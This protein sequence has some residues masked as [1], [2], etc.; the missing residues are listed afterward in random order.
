MQNNKIHLGVVA[1]IA[2][3]SLWFFSCKA[4]PGIE[5]VNT[6]VIKLEEFKAKKKFAEDSISH[7]PGIAEESL[8]PVL[9][10]KINAAADDFIKV[11]RNGNAT[12]KE[13]QKAIG[14]GLGRFSDMYADTENSER[15]CAYFEELMDIVGLE[16]SDGQLNNFLYGFDPTKKEE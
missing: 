4:K 16:S 10:S 12:D 11:A 13:Y 1:F 14:I 15:I 9:T 5:D 7:Y 8:R 3:I 6:I 2:I